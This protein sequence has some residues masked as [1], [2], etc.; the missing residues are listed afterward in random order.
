[1]IGCAAFCRF[2]TGS[3][4][5]D[6]AP[7]SAAVD[8]MALARAF[9]SWVVS[10][11]A[12][13]STVVAI[14]GKT[15]RGT[16]EGK[17]GGGALHLVSGIALAAGRSKRRAMRSPPFLNFS[18]SWRSRGPSSPST[19]SRGKKAI[20]RKIIDKG[21][22]YLLALK[23]NQ[24]SL[25]ADLEWRLSDAGHGRIE[26]RKARV[27]DAAWLAERHPQWPDLRSIAAIIATRTS[28][29]TRETSTETCLYISS[30]PPDPA[31]I[32]SA[33]RSHWSIGNDQHWQFDVTFREDECRTR[34]DHTA[35]NPVMMRHATLNLLTRQNLHQAKAPQSG[36][37]PRT[38]LLTVSDS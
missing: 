18:T 8:P 33:C 34:T 27:A 22:D 38:A 21:G 12:K 15:L 6:A 37:Q 28:K 30:L 25:H 11:E 13:V 24:G 1:L 9:S 3:R 23:E 2:A 7:S 32:L 4:G 10:L 14:D 36:D 20:A 5:A 29:K 26:E 19:R 17:S 35:T 16:T 31:P